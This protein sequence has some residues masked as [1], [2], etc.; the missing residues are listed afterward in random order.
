M[1]RLLLHIFMTVFLVAVP[2]TIQ[3]NEVQNIPNH[4][5]VVSF[6]TDPGW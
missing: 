6:G 4:S 2:L 5:Q 3:A 1:N